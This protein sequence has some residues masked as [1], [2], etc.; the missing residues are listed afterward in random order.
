MN[1]AC[2]FHQQQSHALFFVH[3]AAA[4]STFQKLLIRQAFCLF[5]IPGQSS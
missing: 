5:L 4:S 3:R 2:P 1:F